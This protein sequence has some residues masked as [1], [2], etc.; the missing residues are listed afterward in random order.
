MCDR[1]NVRLKDVV[2][3]TYPPVIKLSALLN[4]VVLLIENND[5]SRE[6]SRLV[7]AIIFSK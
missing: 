5:I 2:C 6:H 1:S 4:K 3:T 7:G